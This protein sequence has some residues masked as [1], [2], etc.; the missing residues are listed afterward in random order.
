MFWSY[1]SPSP[2]YSQIL[3]HLPRQSLFS[4]L[5]FSA[6]RVQLGLSNY[7][8]MWGLPWSVASKWDITTLKKAD[9][10]CPSSNQMAVVP[11]IVVGLM[12]PPPL[13]HAGFYLPWVCTNLAYVILIS[14]CSCPVTSGKC[15]VLELIHHRWLLPSSHLLYPIDLWAMKRGMWYRHYSWGCSLRSLFD[16]PVVGL[17]LLLFW[18]KLSTINPVTFLGIQHQSGNADVD[19]LWGWATIRFYAP[20]VYRWS[21]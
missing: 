5:S 9:F 15:C 6:H 18:R 3:S 11:Q 21:C 13:L 7:S 12:C 16:C 2:N 10:P 8:W 17:Q 19:N 1:S 4:L 14:M 20:L